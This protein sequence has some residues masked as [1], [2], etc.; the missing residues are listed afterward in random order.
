M[1]YRGRFLL[2]ITLACLSMMSLTG[3]ATSSGTKELSPSNPLI[4]DMSEEQPDEPQTP[5]LSPTPPAPTSQSSVTI[6]STNQYVEVGSGVWIVLTA[7]DRGSVLKGSESEYPGFT[8]DKTTV[9][10]FIEVSLQVEN[11]GTITETFVSEP[12]IIDNK[13]R[14]YKPMSFDAY[15]WIPEDELYLSDLQPGVPVKWT[16]IYEVA[17]DASG[18]KLE[19]GDISV[20]GTDTVLIDLGL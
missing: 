6:Y 3:C 4:I 15:E 19:V 13:Q 5:T 9:G 14:Q 17:K 10:K 12:N 8:D 1:I 16:G 7:R 20:W 18:L 11:I 2:I